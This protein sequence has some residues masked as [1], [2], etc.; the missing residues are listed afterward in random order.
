MI[1]VVRDLTR[2]GLKEAKDLVDT[3][4]TRVLAGLG[5]DEAEAACEA[6]LRVGAGAQAEVT[7][8]Q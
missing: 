7:P 8:S 4:P 5:R 3:A 2:L 1:R 6:L